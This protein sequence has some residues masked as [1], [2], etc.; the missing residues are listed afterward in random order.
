MSLAFKSLDAT[1]IDEFNQYSVMRDIYLSESQFVNQF[2][3]S[4]YYKTKYYANGKYLLF[5]MEINKQPGTMVPL[6]KDTDIL[7]AFCDLKK[8]F[9]EKLNLPL[10]VYNVDKLTLEVLKE[11]K[12]FNDK[13]EIVPSRDTSDY[14]YDAGKLK[15]LSGRALHK[16]KNH[17][18]QFIKNYDG[19]YEYRSLNCTNI[20]E[21]QDFHIKWLENREIVDEK[22]LFQSEETGVFNV[23]ENCSL[24]DSKMGGIYVDGK[25]SAYSIGS[26]SPR[27]KCA[28]IHIEKAD[29]AMR[30][31]Y[32]LINQQFLIHEY[33]DAVL[34]NR[35]DDLGHEGLRQSKMSY[36]PIYLVDKFHVFEK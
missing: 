20:K 29:I 5:L 11:S 22:N 23:F 34:V 4:N 21:I 12:E 8:F 16:K 27:T 31:L 3:W 7:E 30:G 26:Y 35:E 2:I 28:F 17:L 33:P 19:R 36:N 32:N 9:N 10:K 15:T 14:M 24:L 18:N 6:C 13:F 25:L 1:C